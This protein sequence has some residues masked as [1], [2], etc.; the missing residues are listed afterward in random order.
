M[1]RAVQC[2]GTF[3]CR[4]TGQPLDGPLCL[5]ARLTI[6]AAGL[7]FAACASATVCPPL[8][9]PS[10][11]VVTDWNCATLTEITPVASKIGPPPAARA[12]AIA[13]TCMYDAWSVYD[14]TAASTLGNTPRRPAS[15]RTNANKA[16]AISYAAYNCL[17][18]LF[19]QAPGD[20]PA[21]RLAAVMTA[22][23]YDPNDTSTDL[24]TPQG[25][26]NVAAARVIHFRRNDG[27]NQYGNLSASGVPYSDYTGYT[28]R[29]APLPYCTPQ[30][31]AS[32]SCL[33]LNVADPLHWQ[34]LTSVTGATQ[35]F[36]TPFW[37]RV[38]PFA[39]TAATEFDKQ[40]P[41]PDIQADPT[42][43]PAQNAHYQANV[44]FTVQNSEA[45]DLQRKLIVEY[46]ADGPNSVLPPGH[47]GFF[48]QFVSARDQHSID[49]D[50]KM[51]FAMHNASFDASIVCWH[52]KRQYDGVRPITAARY[53]AQGTTVTALGGPGAGGPVFTPP[54]TQLGAPPVGTANAMYLAQGWIPYNPGS[55]L[56]PSFPAYFSGHS[57]F[58]SASATVLKLVTGSDTFGYSQV[59]PTDLGRVEPCPPYFC[60]TGIPAVPTTFTYPT[61]SSAAAEAGQ[62][63]LYGGIHFSDDNT[64]GQTVGALVGQQAWALSQLYFAGLIAIDNTSNATSTNATTLSWSHTVGS[65]NNRLLLVGISVGGGSSVLRV[66]YGGQPLRQRLVQN[67]PGNQNRIELWY[68]LAPPSGTANVVATLANAAHVVGGAASFTAVNQSRPFGESTSASGQSATASLNISDTTSDRVVFSVVAA[69]E[70]A[71]PVI[72]AGGETAVWN[73][74][75]GTAST[76]ILG[77]AATEPGAESGVPVS[78]ALATSQP[79]ALGAVALK[80]ALMRMGLSN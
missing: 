64:T 70:G 44:A 40:I 30:T 15:E 42:V 66:T 28:P 7:W 37:E 54:A 59:L 22:H 17:L 76:D 23:G 39:L 5:L 20:A 74:G 25:I 63:R 6:L 10:Q 50:I 60:P 33:P 55:N 16:K 62:S 49:D 48:A 68:L 65:A 57:V 35:H 32:A 73:N 61:F 38:T 41:A 75:S 71:N 56:S 11:T 3:H 34:P 77:A 69:N 79:W 36:I 21:V 52:A 9:V 29:N 1:N 14:A 4:R 53:L 67:G 80:P 2:Y 47:W 12:L 58:S 45:L 51:F 19:S 8:T 27:S 24:T 72:V 43:P 26:G 78:Y 31:A 18:N 13:H 46:W